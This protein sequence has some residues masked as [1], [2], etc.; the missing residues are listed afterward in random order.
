MPR[1]GF[2]RRARRPAPGAR[3]RFVA[4]V[5]LDELLAEA[6]ASEQMAAAQLPRLAVSPPARSTRGYINYSRL[7]Y[8]IVV[9]FDEDEHTMRNTLLHEIAHAVH[10]LHAFERGNCGCERSCEWDGHGPVFKRHLARLEHRFQPGTHS[11]WGLAG[12]RGLVRVPARTPW[13]AAIS[14]PLTADV[15]GAGS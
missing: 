5:W 12:C 13:H 14:C 2:R 15:L 9:R 11:R 10:R 8:R 6:W 4:P 3:R 7:P 1:L